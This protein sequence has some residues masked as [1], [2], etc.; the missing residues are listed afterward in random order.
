VILGAGNGSGTGQEGRKAAK[1]AAEE[2]QGKLA[3]GDTTLLEEARVKAGTFAEFTEGWLKHGRSPS[4]ATDAEK[5][6]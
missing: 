3:L 6:R 1:T 5:S 2:I 4:Q